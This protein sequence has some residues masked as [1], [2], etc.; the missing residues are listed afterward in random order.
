MSSIILVGVVEQLL[1]EGWSNG[2]ALASAAAGRIESCNSCG[3]PHFPHKDGKDSCRKS[4]SQLSYL[5]SELIKA[6]NM[7]E[8]MV[9]NSAYVSAPET[10]S[11]ASIT[12]RYDNARRIGAQLP[13]YLNNVLIPNS[14]G[15]IPV[16]ES[17]LSSS[18][19]YW[20]PYAL[21]GKQEGGYFK[22]MRV[23]LG[24]DKSASMFLCHCSNREVR[25]VS[26]FQ[27]HRCFL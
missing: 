6:E 25:F 21:G 20:F 3:T 7:F 27:L 10:I 24:I 5:R 1:A 4:L 16:S 8:Q 9:T 2:A 26:S 23:N 11:Q 15:Y 14:S 17:D 12:G 19:P 18:A 22:D 13:S